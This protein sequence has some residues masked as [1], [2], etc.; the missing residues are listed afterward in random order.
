MVLIDFSL[1]GPGDDNAA[2]NSALHEVR[3]TQVVVP[4]WLTQRTSDAC[5]E[6]E[7][8]RG[9]GGAPPRERMLFAQQVLADVGPRLW[10]GHDDIEVDFDGRVRSFCP[11]TRAQWQSG[12]RL[13]VE[14]PSTALLATVLATQ[15]S[16][17]IGKALDGCEQSEA[18]VLSLA[19]QARSEVGVA[20]I[21]GPVCGITPEAAAPRHLGFVQDADTNP[22]SPHRLPDTEFLHLKLT[23]GQPALLDADALRDAI[24]VIGASHEMSTDKVLTPLG[25]MPG[26]M[27]LVNVIHESMAQGLAEHAELS[28]WLEILIEMLVVV[29]G[30]FLFVLLQDGGVWLG[31]QMT[32]GPAHSQSHPAVRP[33]RSWTAILREL[34]HGLARMLWIMASAALAL[35]FLVWLLVCVSGITAAYWP[36]M[37]DLS[38]AALGMLLDLGARMDEAAKQLFG[39]EDGH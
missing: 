16:A 31:R 6:D 35:F 8:R 37:I 34:P 14:L 21:E 32:G 36:G 5:I 24:V 28:M 1:S 10:L 26:V 17:R 23:P 30:A 25:V 20:G 38:G 39:S 4:A 3:H 19:R 27:L 9:R 12:A 13:S 18:L 15:G 11:V 29:V 2:L 7:A 22:G 33:H